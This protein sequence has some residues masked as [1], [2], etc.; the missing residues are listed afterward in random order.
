[1][2][3]WLRFDAAEASCSKRCRR[4]PVGS[5]FLAEDLDRDLAPELHVLGEID[6]THSA[7]AELLENSIM[8]NF[9]RIHLSV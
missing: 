8:G 7:G 6:L 1:M 2:F 3:G 5:E 4:S 9:I